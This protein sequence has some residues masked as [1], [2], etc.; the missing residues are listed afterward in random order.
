MLVFSKARNWKCQ[1]QARL[2]SVL[3]ILL[4]LWMSPADFHFRWSGKVWFL[5]ELKLIH[6][7]HKIYITRYVVIASEKSVFSLK[8]LI[9]RQTG[10][11]SSSSS[12]GKNRNHTIAF[13]NK[14]DTHVMCGRQKHFELYP[15]RE[16]VYDLM[17]SKNGST[18]NTW[19]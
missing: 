11:G 17:Q 14:Y 13:I 4:L 8:M 1:K 7:N 6:K 9:K 19:V 12:S 15:I 18:Q 3:V 5:C 10:S 16:S 2:M